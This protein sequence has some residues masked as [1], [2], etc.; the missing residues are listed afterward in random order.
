MLG[1]VVGDIIGS[2]FEGSCAS[3]RR[4]PLFIDG[5]ILTDDTVCTIAVIETI[6]SGSDARDTLQRWCRQ[7]PRAGYGPRFLEWVH[8]ES[9]KP[10]QSYGNGALMRVSPAIA[11]ASSLAEA[12]QWA[13]AVTVVSHDHPLALAA[14][15][16]YTEALWLA[17]NTHNHTE[18][19]KLLQHR[20]VSYWN[21]EDIHTRG[22]SAKD[23][24]CDDALE[25]VLSCLRVTSDFE[26]LMRECLYFGG[27]TDTVA[28][29]AG[30]IGE[31]LWGIPDHLIRPTWARIPPEMQDL[32]FREYDVI[33]ARYPHLPRGK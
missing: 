7:Y 32:V 3:H 22:N 6:L 9:P 4:T 33:A 18:V 30:S 20:G 23:T 28:A 10:Y 2:V 12:K 1:A 19:C 29:I 17:L 21:V 8:A 15:D 13:H 31:A 11:L 16:L 14:V 27:D 5:S 25:A 24:S 26:S